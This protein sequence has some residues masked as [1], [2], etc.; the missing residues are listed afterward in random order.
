MVVRW[1]WNEAPQPLSSL[2]AVTLFTEPFGFG[3]ASGPYG[4]LAW[5]MI[6]VV[7]WAELK[8]LSLQMQVLVELR[9]S[10][11]RGSNEDVDE[12]RGQKKNGGQDFQKR[13]AHLYHHQL[14]GC[15]AFSC[16]LLQTLVMCVFCFYL[17]ICYLW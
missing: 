4:V 14:R 10:E 6:G 1:G 5:T 9:R 17:S 12:E 16:W 2:R 13:V 11:E 15:G 7:T 3:E 8:I